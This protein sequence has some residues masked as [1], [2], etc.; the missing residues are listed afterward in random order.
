MSVAPG[1]LDLEVTLHLE[2]LMS[3]DA[4]GF[5]PRGRNHPVAF[6]PPLLEKEGRKRRS[7]P[8]LLPEEGCLRSRRGGGSLPEEG[9]GLFEG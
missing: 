3:F 1:V 8:P 6:A 2:L 9:L 4:V 7:S 5:A